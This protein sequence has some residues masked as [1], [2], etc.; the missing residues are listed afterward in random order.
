MG[1]PR[2]VS[3][4]T[5]VDAGAPVPFNPVNASFMDIKDKKHVDHVACEVRA[6]S[7]VYG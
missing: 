4:P 6:L 3:T 5:V 1:L 7:L 2:T